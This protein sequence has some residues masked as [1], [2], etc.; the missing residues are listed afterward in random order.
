MDSAVPIEGLDAGIFS[1]E[2]RPH[3][4]DRLHG[5]KGRAGLHQKGHEFAGAGAEIDNNLARSQAKILAQPIDERRRIA[6]SALGVAGRPL[7]RSPP[8]AEG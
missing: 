3:R 4:G 8:L 7:R 5:K 2:L 6:G 1:F